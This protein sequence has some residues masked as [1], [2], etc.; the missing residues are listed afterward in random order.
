MA[1]ES[2]VK[3][4]EIADTFEQQ[5]E[6]DE[7]PQIEDFLSGL[8]DEAQRLA[9]LRELIEIELEFRLRRGPVLAVAS[10][11]VLLVDDYIRRFPQLAAC[12]H[13]VRE[14]AIAEY[15]ARHRFG[16]A[17][18]MEAFVER[19]PR[20]PVT[21]QELRRV[22]TRMLRAHVRVYN[23]T[24]LLLTTPLDEELHLGRQRSTDP[25]VALSC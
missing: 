5:L 11:T 9:V 1:D 22:L 2:F 6:Q 4:D 17:P 24:T 10:P 18:P 20:C 16:D 7:R 25:E 3:L 8:A 21:K 15:R 13:V 14:L 23:K 19:F 12:D